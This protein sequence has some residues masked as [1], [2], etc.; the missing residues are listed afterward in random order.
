MKALR[1]F[2]VRPSLPGELSAL[3]EL[4]FNLRWSWDDQTRDLF[5]WVD[6]D[7]WDASVHDPV[8]L[9]GLVPRERFD[10]LAADAG[11]KRFLEDVH[12]EL[13]RY[14]E[15]DRWF[16]A[17]GAGP[18][19]LVAYFSPEFG[20]AEAVPQYSGGLGVLA[21]DHLKAASDLGVPLVGVGL[22]YRHGY[23]RQ[24]L[25]ADGWQQERYPLLDPHIMALTLC[26]DVRVEVDLAGVPLV[27]QVW[28]ACVGRVPLYFLDADVDDNPDDIRQ[29]TDR[30]YGGDTEH[31]LRQEILLGI[32]GVRAL[33]A[34]GVDAQVFHTN[35]G[36]AGFLGIER[37]RQLVVEHGLAYPEAIEA[38][39]AG[40]I[41]TTH[42]P[43]PAGIDRFPRELMEKY[44]GG[45]AHEV[46][47][48]ID[49]LIALGHRPT[50]DHEA[51]FNMA[52]M[53]LRLAGRSN[54]VAKLH[55][56]VSREMFGDLWPDLESDETPIGS[57]TNGVHAHT[58]TSPEM[59]DVLSRHVR[60]DWH[61][62]EPE[63][64]Q[65]VAEAPD[66][67]LWRAREQARE[68]MVSFVRRRLKEAAAARGLTGSDVAWTDE[69]LDPRALTIGFARRF[70]T[71]K[72]AT[73]LLSQPDRL[74]ALLLSPDHPVQLVFAGKAHPA[75]EQGK[76]MI[77]QIVAFAA[78]PEIRHRF[79]FVDDY[80]IAVARA[81][82]QGC[83][84]WLNNPRRPQEACGTSGMKAALNGGLNLSI[85]DGW[86]HEMFDGG[87]GWAIS[88]AEHVDDL[89]RRDALEA[90]A[91]FD[92][93]ERQVVPLYYE[94]YGGPLPRRWLKKVRRSLASLGPRVTA[95]RMVRDY[96]SELYEP[97]AARTDE[98]SGDG[99]ARA[100]A[101][102]AWK[103][104]VRD[105]WHGVHVDRVEGELGVADLGGS[106]TVEAVVSLGSLSAGDVD[107]QLVHGPVGQADELTS[108][109]TVSMT[110][111]GPADDGHVRY[112]GSFETSSAGRY[113][114]TVRVVPRHPDLV[115]PPEMGLAAWA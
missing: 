112:A 107:V 2:T 56:E 102:A 76:E 32:G 64:W 30:L 93:L 44:F 49:D 19:G 34:V 3:E 92:L 46:G 84:V 17:R 80:D 91:L 31:R 71:Y 50:D 5:R 48:D 90:S 54:G 105:A 97:T 36:H 89:G 83:D 62:A 14:Q 24:S 1:S 98:L 100:R 4:A 6:P 35:E 96:V 45:W 88:S 82:Y 110:Q 61:E 26:E 113:G 25:D 57:I 74:R 28:K 65:R 27:A 43:V 18:L 37:I 41:F 115:G 79:V 78:D 72:R 94:R 108:R 22:L 101:L 7:L 59:T 85:L 10:A 38:V 53:G 73:L 103:Q 29:V 66:D 114:F 42:T 13:Q 15:G 8:R 70:A 55:G 58:W 67:E 104:R 75:D 40:C 87:N 12:G 95:S 63:L 21:G 20:I 86:W 9:L 52:V 39:R 47:V 81:L 11:F 69:V 16:Q 99:F 109:A 111:A 23:F 51:P 33:Q 68:R 106:R 77:R 60:P